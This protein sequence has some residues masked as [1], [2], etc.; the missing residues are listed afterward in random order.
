MSQ[1]RVPRMQTN[2]VWLFPPIDFKAGGK[3]VDITAWTFTGIAAGKA[4]RVTLDDQR[5]SIVNNKLVLTLS[6]DDCATLGVGR[7]E[8]ELDRTAPA[9]APVPILRFSIPNHAAL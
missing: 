4:G 3:A 8:I 1:H 6:A 7:V 9:P 2:S 5:L